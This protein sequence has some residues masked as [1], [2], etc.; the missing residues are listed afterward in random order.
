MWNNPVEQ[1]LFL[2]SKED[3]YDHYTAVHCLATAHGTTKVHL[4]NF[5]EHDNAQLCT[6]AIQEAKPSLTWHFSP[7]PAPALVIQVLYPL[8]QKIYKRKREDALKNKLFVQKR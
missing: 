3:H 4:E 1:N 5:A 8:Y 6:Q 2:R 7:V